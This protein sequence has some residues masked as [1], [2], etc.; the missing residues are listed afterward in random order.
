MMT[1]KRAALAGAFCAI[2][3]F[4]SLA[5]FTFHALTW[6][7]ARARIEL[8]ETP[9]L[10]RFDLL[11]NVA[12]FVP[13][14]FFLAGALRQRHGAAVTAARVVIVTAVL[15][16]AVETA[17]IYLPTRTPAV[18]DF[19]AEQT[20]AAVGIALWAACGQWLVLWTQRLSRHR[21][22]AGLAVRLL[23]AFV[24][25]WSVARLF[26]FN[27][28]I[29]VHQLAQRVRDGQIVL[30]PFAGGD[31]PA[32]LAAEAIMATPIGFLATLGW[33]TPGV[34][35]RPAAAAAI[36]LVF[37]GAVGVA[38]G[39]IDSQAFDITR[40]GTAVAGA[41]GGVALAVAL[42]RSVA[43]LHRSERVA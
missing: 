18:S 28:T 37:T 2:A 23:A 19:C 5:P 21:E 34:R 43:R 12:L 20:G 29:E 10:S 1:S 42:S 36:A 27:A 35:R 31:S 40:V 7:Q 8:P 13:I 4:G 3:V 25:I 39:L 17:Q 26:P 33:T 9:G 30:T 38:Q 16:A 24:V 32:R 15:S 6:D 14:G 22:P 11:D 41:L